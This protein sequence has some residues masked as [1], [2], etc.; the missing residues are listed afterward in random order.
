MKDEYKGVA[1]S[2]FVGLRAKLYAIQDTH[3]ENRKRVKGIRKNVVE[4]NITFDDFKHC[5][6]SEEMQRREQMQIRSEKHDIFTE[7]VNK[8]ALESHDDKRCILDCNI[9]T[10]PWGHYRLE[11]GRACY[12]CT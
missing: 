5:L 2:E 1:L 8:V 6:Q 11:Y 4:Q 12:Q 10:L 3:N 7:K 9:H